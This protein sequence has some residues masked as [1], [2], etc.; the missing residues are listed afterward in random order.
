MFL[1]AMCVLGVCASVHL[2][3]AQIINENLKLT[4]PDGAAEDRYGFAV[5]IEGGMVL[6]GSPFDDDFGVDSGSVYV[7]TAQQTFKL[8]AS[9]ADAGDRF[10]SSVDISGSYAVVG[11]PYN[12]DAG[13]GTGAA[14]VFDLTNGQQIYKL[15]APVPDGA[16][17]FG[18]SVAIDGNTAVIG[19]DGAHDGFTATG[20]A[21]VFDLTT[22]LMVHK[23][24]DAVAGPLDRFGSA[25]DISG[26]IA[27]IGE[28]GDNG[29]PNDVGAAYF[30]DVT[31]GQELHKLIPSDGA[32]EDRFGR[33]VAIEGDRA[34]IGAYRD[35]DD[36][37]DSG[38]AYIF[39]VTTGQELLKLTASDASG[40]SY[41]GYSVAIDHQHAV[42]GAPLGG[43]TTPGGTCYVYDLSTGKEQ[44]ML[45]PS[46]EAITGWF[47]YSAAVDDG[48]T[49]VGAYLED[50]LATNA[51]AAYLFDIVLCP[52]DITGDGNLDFFD[53]SAFLSAFAAGD[54]IADFT[55]DGAFDFFD[56]SAFL[57]AFS[58]GCP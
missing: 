29:V 56:V 4:A 11:A 24:T 52:A 1:K 37:N 51:G 57:A 36:G 3:S 12:S 49:V 32:S 54:P 31:T 6:V 20:A 40:T 38:S 30:F 47:G 35:D 9:D 23:L 39:D 5:A 43:A 2:A 8:N 45:I 34:V 16:E 22:G 58:A 13:F 7:R 46:D 10:G 33:S 14:Y 19:A 21:F 44:A 18:G 41:F 42:I 50:E 53:V 27:V 55:G 17:Y 15:L 25:V 48:L 26:N 28:W